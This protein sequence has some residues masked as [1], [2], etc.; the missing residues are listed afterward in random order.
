MERIRAAGNAYPKL[1]GKGAALRH[2]A[3]FAKEIVESHHNGT[4][5]DDLVQGVITLLCKIYGIIDSGSQFMSDAAKDLLPKI[6]RKFC[7]LYADLATQSAEIY[8]ELLW[9]LSPE[10]HL[11]DNLLE[12]QTAI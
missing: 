2:L 1:K 7:Q 9:K 6:S 3:W 4:P 8:E 5:H 12:M 11:M 10:H